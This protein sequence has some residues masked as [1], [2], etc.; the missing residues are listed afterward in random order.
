MLVEMRRVLKNKG[1]LKKG[2]KVILT[3]GDVANISGGTN[4]LRIIEVS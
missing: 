3:Y 2:D 1:L 4:T